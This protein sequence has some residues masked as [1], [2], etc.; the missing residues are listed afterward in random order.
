VLP[1]LLFLIASTLMPA[2]KRLLIINTGG[3]IGM[4]A[5]PSGYRPAAGFLGEQLQAFPEMRGGQ[6]PGFEIIE[7]DPLLD[8]ANFTPADW[9]R[10]AGD[11]AE[12]HDKYDAFLV[13]HGTDTMAY[14]ASALPLMLPGLSRNVIVTG[15][16]LPLCL[17][18]TDARENLITAMI[19][20]SEYD[21]PE[22]CVLFGSVL[23]R[24]C[25]STK[26][27]ATSFDAF[28]SPNAPPLA[29][30]GT[31]IRVFADRIRYPESRQGGPLQVR[32]IA[33]SGVATLRLFPG[34][35]PRILANVL[36][37]PLRGLVLES[38]GAGNGPSDNQDFLQVLRDADQR[39][40]VIVNIS[41]CRHGEVSQT[42]YATGR[43]MHDAGVVSGRDM[44]V[45]AA[46]TKLMFLFDHC[47]SVEQVKQQIGT[48]LVGEITERVL[49][50]TD[51]SRDTP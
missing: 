43:A 1:N 23:L 14:T 31:H 19:V 5:G 22:V 47:D 27:S 50:S 30:I 33:G 7:Y 37:T 32:S 42:E 51:R 4:K 13:L 24:G 40:I 3:T 11:I 8:S 9:R 12:K 26:V 25:R 41:Q 2:T 16:Q 45:E 49:S 18:R 17:R 34:F 39:G 10:I 48:N 15:S 21:I 28:D 44:T 38:Y 6:M 36:Q 35:D 46:L 20:A 29:T